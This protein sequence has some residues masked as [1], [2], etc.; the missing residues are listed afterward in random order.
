M[1]FLPRYIVVSLAP[2]SRAFC[3]AARTLLYGKLDLRTIRPAHFDQ[4]NTL[5]ASRRDL[6]DIVHTFICHTW[7][8][9]FYLRFNDSDA[10]ISLLSSSTVTFTIA[11][12]NMNHL[13]SLTLPSFDLALLQHHTAF[14]L[15]SITFLNRKMSPQEQTELFTWMDGQTNITSL[16]FPNLLEKTDTTPPSPHTHFR[17]RTH[18]SIHRAPDTPIR[19]SK[20][21]IFA[22]TP[23]SPR[24][25]YPF[26][27]TTL[28]PALTALHAP[29]ILTTLLVPTR[30]LT[31]V[32]LTIHAT[33]YT[34]LRPAAI[35][36]SL[37]GVTN[38]G[39]RFRENVDRRTV[40]KVLGAAGAAL[41]EVRGFDDEAKNR[42]LDTLE[43]EVAWSDDGTD[44][45]GYSLPWII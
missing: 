3:S 25:S 13:T 43:V 20:S 7:S 36:S 27:S 18:A 16:A 23:A 1:S 33:L 38:L 12:Q 28:L 24:S 8:P 2:I 26:N 19:P 42:S 44:E 10:R 29:P 5:L 4:L 37:R 41:G 30:H 9:S 17:T 21:S 40:E 22:F 11:L 35:M 39:V 31:H 14:G 15:K 45:V 32:T 6:A 34:G